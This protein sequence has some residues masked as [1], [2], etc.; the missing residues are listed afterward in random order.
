VVSRWLA[1]GQVSAIES[2]AKIAKMAACRP[3][4]RS[5]GRRSAMRYRAAGT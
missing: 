1:S 2:A 5:A 4:F 3:N